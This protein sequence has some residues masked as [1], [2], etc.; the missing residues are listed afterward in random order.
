MDNVEYKLNGTY[1]KYQKKGFWNRTTNVIKKIARYSLIATTLAITIATAVGCDSSG[2]E[3]DSQCKNDRVCYYG[4]CVTPDEANGKS[5]GNNN[6]DD[7]FEV[8]E[9]TGC[10]PKPWFIDEDGDGYGTIQL[11]A[12]MCSCSA[13]FVDNADDC[14]DYNPNAYP[15]G[16]QDCNG[17]GDV[18]SLTDN[19][20]KI[21]K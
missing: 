5:K 11:M 16:P 14:N 19:I 12:A 3:Y 7:I 4:N 15:G 20:L 2:C 6:I 8:I 9:D 21:L 1:E 10:T 13:G 17:V 18:K